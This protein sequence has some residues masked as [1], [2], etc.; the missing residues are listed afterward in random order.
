MFGKILDPSNPVA[1]FLSAL[2]D[3]ALLNILWI[4]FSLPIFTTGAAI[5]AVN[6][7]S[8]RILRDKTSS[9]MKPF[10]DS[11]R[12]N[13]KQATIIWLILLAIIAVL[14]V[15]LRF[16]LFAQSF[17]TGVVQAL[18]CGILILLLLDALLVMIYAF[19]LLSL[20]ENTVK[21]TLKN[22]VLFVLRNPIRSLGALGVDVLL[23]A[24][25]VY[26]PFSNIPLLAV[27]MILMGFALMLFLNCLIL[28]P[29]F[30]P[31][32]PKDEEITD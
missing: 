26:A 14:C 7:V 29:V 20:F 19:A 28:M 15:D 6:A 18:I 4:V 31:Y 5:T 16:I 9:I 1:R 2:F 21:E 22:A 27:A 17:F 30:K 32:L 24:L 10:W 3:I 8:F 13:F 12:M 11:F 25:A 23:L